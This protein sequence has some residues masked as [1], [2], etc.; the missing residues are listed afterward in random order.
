MSVACC[1][2]KQVLL[3]STPM[4]FSPGCSNHHIPGYMQVSALVYQLRG[5]VACMAEQPM[6]QCQSA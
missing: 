4:A 3:L 6:M 2:G 5:A 1:A